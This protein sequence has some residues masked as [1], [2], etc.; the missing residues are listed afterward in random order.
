MSWDEKILSD[1]NNALKQQGKQGT[2]PAPAPAQPA[3]KKPL[4]MSAIEASIQASIRGSKPQ[5]QTPPPPAPAPK[6]AVVEKDL[7]GFGDASDAFD[8]GDID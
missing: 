8:L 1:I 7:S 6:P 5:S 2:T 4:D 3:Q